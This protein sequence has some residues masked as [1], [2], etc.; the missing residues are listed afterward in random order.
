[1]TEHD[2]RKLMLLQNNL[3]AGILR[4][5]LGMKERPNKKRKSLK[6]AQDDFKKLIESINPFLPGLDK[7]VLPSPSQWGLP[8]FPRCKQEKYTLL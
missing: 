2:L 5:T 7:Q 4:V 3:S 8:E 1:M 6:K